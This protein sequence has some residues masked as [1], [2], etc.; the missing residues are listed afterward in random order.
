M[1]V[2]QEVEDG[3]ADKNVENVN[4]GGAVEGDVSAPNDEVP[5]VDCYMDVDSDVVLE[6]AKE[7]VDDAKYNQDFDVQEEESEPVELQEL[8]DI[9]T[10]A[11][12]ITEV[13]NAASTT[14]TADEAKEDKS[15]KRKQA[16]KRKP[17]T[18]AQAI[19]NM[20]VYLKNVVGFKMDYFKDKEQI[21]EE[22]SRAL[23]RINETQAEKAAKRQ[24]LNK[25]V[26]ELKRHL[27][28]VPNKD[29]DVYTKATLPAQKVPVVDYEI[30]NQNNKPYNKI[31]RADGTHQLYISFL[32]LL[33]NFDRE[34]LEALW[35]LVKERFAIAKPKNFFDD[36]LLITL[37]AIKSQGL[38]VVGIMWCA[39]HYIYNHTADFVSREEVP[40]HKP[41]AIG[42]SG[43]KDKSISSMKE[44]IS[45]TRIRD[46]EKDL[47][48]ASEFLE[49]NSFNGR[50]DELS[51]TNFLIR[52]ISSS[53]SQPVSS[54]PGGIDLRREVAG[55]EIGQ[56]QKNLN[57]SK[58]SAHDN[59]LHSLVNTGNSYEIPH[60][61]HNK[62]H[63]RSI[64]HIDKP[65]EDPHNGYNK[66]ILV[67]NFVNF[68]GN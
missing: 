62:A 33:R 51:Y 40:T 56:N 39:D 17:Q 54:I 30:I 67:E 41:G 22:E 50:G 11:K 2:A 65:H 29:D 44:S 60:S 5:T 37:G 63:R 7:V 36:F 18:K 35:S 53:G 4:A 21:E 23:K 47:I 16:I 52:R 68:M 31:I 46:E 58:N 27:Q 26:E 25:E 42:S 66:N 19:K 57:S 45:S 10:T 15:V 34:D 20:M 1:L 64:N 8:V 12:S 48:A 61:F 28:I 55:V 3:N 9:V 32:S 59:N 14:I 24:K 6:E 43:V 13:I 49:I 38:E